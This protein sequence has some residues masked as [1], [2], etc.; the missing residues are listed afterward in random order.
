MICSPSPGYLIAI[1]FPKVSHRER[2][3]SSVN[4]VESDVQLSN[5]DLLTPTTKAIQKL[6]NICA[7]SPRT[8]SVAADYWFLVFSVMLKIASCNCTS[9]LLKYRDSC[10]HDC[11]EWES[12]RLW[13]A[14][15]YSFSADR[16]DLRLS[17]QRGKLWRGIAMLHDNARPNPARQ[18]T[19][20]LREQFH[21][22][23]FEHPP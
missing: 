10:G 23:I 17:R 16:W 15:C 4:L 19:S 11:T 6:K 2:Y 5:T 7:Y 13:G 20:L 18:T 21:W 12:R 14:R 1:Y 9:D 22:D 8:C 3:C